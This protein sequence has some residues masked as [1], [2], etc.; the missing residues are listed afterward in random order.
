MVDV[1]KMFEH[2]NV[3]ILASDANFKV[4]YQNKKCRQLFEREF[5]RA[6]YTG[7]DLNECH[8]HET[9]EKI[10][11]YFKEYKEKKRLLDYYFMDE[12]ENKITV[13]NVPFYDEDEFAGVVE[14]IFESSLE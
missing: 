7:A 14:F 4:I 5:E 11:G 2:I 6:D 1:R 13:V 8:K 10:K 12:S 3:A 9:T